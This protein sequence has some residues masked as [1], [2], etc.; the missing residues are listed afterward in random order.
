M[1][2]AMVLRTSDT[3]RDRAGVTEPGEDFGTPHLLENFFGNVHGAFKSGAGQ[4]HTELISTA[5][6]DKVC[7]SHDVFEDFCD[8]RQYFVADNVAESVVDDLEAIDIEH[9]Q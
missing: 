5:P 8:L 4:D 9:Q 1:A 2:S 7:I 6:E 3:H